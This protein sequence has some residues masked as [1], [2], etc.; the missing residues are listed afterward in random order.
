M[1]Q[2]T[3]P[4]VYRVL[5]R[6]LKWGLAVFFQKI[7]VRHGENIP[8]RGPVLFVANHPNS[9]MDALVLG[10]ISNRMVHYIGHAGLF[11][12]KLMAW[13]LGSCGVIP[14][15]RR[16]GEEDRAERNVEAFE[17]CYQVLERSGAIG[18]FPEGTSDMSHLVKKAKTGAARIV[19][20]AERRNAYA[21]GVRVIPVGLHFF[22]R[23]R[24]RSRVLVNVGWPID[25]GPYLAIDA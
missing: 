2:K 4:I 12:H 22:S 15:L 20:E 13:L 5:Q 10:G 6:L 23:S 25:L 16:R 11:A 18:I 8:E 19:L 9:T 3:I 24:F 17:A 14:V 7:E 21:L 1:T